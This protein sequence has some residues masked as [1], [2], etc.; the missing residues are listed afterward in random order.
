[1]HDA[2]EEV[3]VALNEARKAAPVFSNQ[4][5]LVRINTR[6]QVHP[7][8]AQSW[9]TRL[10]KYIVIAAN[11]GYMEGR[12]NFSARTSG[13][14]NLLDFFIRIKL[15]EGEGSFGLGH[16]QASGG[17]LPIARWNELL[18]KLG[19]PASVHARGK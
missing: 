3:K 6:C 13:D 15:T 9:R 8:I 17:S 11:E 10:P 4:V 2:R 18:G 19:F 16:D 5:A 12:V 14:T 7:L 1:M